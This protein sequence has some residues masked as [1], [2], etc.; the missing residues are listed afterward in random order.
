MSGYLRLMAFLD[1]PFAQSNIWLN[2]STRTD[3]EAG[4]L[5]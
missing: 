2:I 1:E 4:N 5:E 3:G